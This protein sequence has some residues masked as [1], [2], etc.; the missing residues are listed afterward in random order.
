MI[1]SFKDKDTRRFFQGARVIR[2]EAFSEQANRRM[3]ILNNAR[4]LGDLAGLPGNRL[5]R[6]RGDRE[7]E[8]S[9]RVNDQWRICFRWSDDGPC[10]VEIVDYH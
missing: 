9:I 8:H 4:S 5:E 7:G 3:T 1:R 6:L 2:F 10:E